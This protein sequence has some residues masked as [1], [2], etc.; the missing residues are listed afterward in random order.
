MIKYPNIGPFL[1][2]PTILILRSSL[3]LN[4]VSNAIFPN[5]DLMV[6]WANCVIAYSA[7]ST[8]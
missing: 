6:V 8:P 7:S 1:F 4:T 3:S 5:S 2:L